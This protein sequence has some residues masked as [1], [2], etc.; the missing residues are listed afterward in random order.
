MSLRGR[1][2][3]A[4]VAIGAAFTLVA[5][6][7]VWRKDI[8]PTALALGAFLALGGSL[9]IRRAAPL[10]ALVVGLGAMLVAVSG[11]VSLESPVSP[12]LFFV[13]VL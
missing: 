9:T 3:A 8:T 10:A 12:L 11:G 5:E 2:T 4:D 6:L 13:F 7:E 1:V